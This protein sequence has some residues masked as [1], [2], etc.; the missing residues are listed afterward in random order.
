MGKMCPLQ[1]ERCNWHGANLKSS[2][3]NWPCG[4]RDWPESEKGADMSWNQTM[5]STV[6]D[7]T[8]QAPEPRPPQSPQG[9]GVRMSRQVQ[10]WFLNW[11]RRGTSQR[12]PRHQLSRGT[13]WG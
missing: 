7:E 5:R 6:E 2:I 13:R 3:H 1:P 8:A 4:L 11:I 9:L 12:V 10:G